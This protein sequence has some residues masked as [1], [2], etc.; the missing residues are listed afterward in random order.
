MKHF[1]NRT[2]GLLTG[3][4]ALLLFVSCDHNEGQEAD[5]SDIPGV[6]SCQEASAYGGIRKY[7]VEVDAVNGRDDLYIISNFHNK[8]QNEFLYVERRDQE[9]DI[10]QQTITDL[11]VD[12]SGSIADDFSRIKLS[13]ETDDGTTILDYSVSYTR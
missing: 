4:L 13:Y 3:L 8:G 5:Y 11:Y 12:G 9:L 1:K 7:I 10:N 6:Y 2:I